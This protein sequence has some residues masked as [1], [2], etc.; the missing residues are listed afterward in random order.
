MIRDHRFNVEEVELASLHRRRKRLF[1]G[2]LSC[3]ALMVVSILLVVVLVPKVPE[4]IRI[5]VVTA[6]SCVGLGYCFVFLPKVRER[7]LEKTKSQRDDYLWLKKQEWREKTDSL[8]TPRW[9]VADE[10]RGNCHFYALTTPDG[11]PVK[12]ESPLRRAMSYRA[13]S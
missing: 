13:K 9:G 4:A 3:L 12:W 2:L 6:V 1:V 7:E 8:G 5:L 11:L 10:W